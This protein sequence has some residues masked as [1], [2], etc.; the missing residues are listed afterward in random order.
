[1]KIINKIITFFLA[2]TFPYV[3]IMLSIR[4]LFTPLFLVFEYNLPGFPV[5]S[6]GFSTEERLKWGSQSIEY[7]FNDRDPAFLEELRFE[8]GTSI[9]NEREISHMVDVKILLAQT[10]IIFYVL[11]LFY[12]LAAFWFRYK[13]QS[14]HIWNAFHKGGWITLGIIGSVLL[15]VII[16]FNALF[17]AFHKVFFAGDTWLFLYSDTLI[18]LF[19]MR[20]WQD[21]FIYMGIITVVIALFFA[22]YGNKKRFPI[23]Q[24]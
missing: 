17:T 13:K 16:S 1:M 14:H 9:Y 4:I 23:I 20:L 15:A 3:I 11:L 8:D 24:N 10:L 22:F 7:L 6:Y 21:A 19:P 12:L 5:D 2:I 18:R